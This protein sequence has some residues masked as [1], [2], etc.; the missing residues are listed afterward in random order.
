[1]VELDYGSVAGLFSSGDLAID[2]SAAEVWASL[3]ALERGDFEDATEHYSMAASR[4]AAAQAVT[5]SN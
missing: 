3:E 1:M 5:Y 2:E 4:W